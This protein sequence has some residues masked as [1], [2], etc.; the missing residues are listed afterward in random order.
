M[1]IKRITAVWDHSTSKGNARLLMLALADS[2]NDDGY[3]WPGYNHIQTKMN[4]GSRGTVSNTIEAQENA[5]ELIVDHRP[6]QGN[7][8][9]VIV[10]FSPEQV[11]HGLRTYFNMNESEVEDA[12]QKLKDRGSTPPKKGNK[13]KNRTNAISTETVLNK[14]KNRTGTSLKTVLDPL[15]PVIEPSNKDQTPQ[16]KTPLATKEQPTQS[17]Q[18]CDMPASADNRLPFFPDGTIS[19][20]EM[21]DHLDLTQADID[22]VKD[23]PETKFGY[24]IG[25][26]AWLVEDSDFHRFPT[27]HE[28]K[29]VRFT[30][31]MVEIE[32]DNGGEL[33]KA[34]RRPHTLSKTRP[35]LER[36]TT[37]IQDVIA[38]CLFGIA[39]DAPIG[40]RT[41]IDLNIYAGEITTPYPTITPE[42]VRAAFAWK[43]E[44]KPSKPSLLVKMLGDYRDYL[45]STQPS[46][47]ATAE[48]VTFIH[49]PA[50]PA[51]NYGMV[52]DGEGKSVQC[53]KCEALKEKGIV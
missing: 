26:T 16:E 43:G 47:G 1:S 28:V 2:A 53:A 42:Q 41:M 36:K 11:K 14:S 49:D 10:G 51:C 38:E 9:L 21:L 25:D 7:K 6:N 40:R 13:S 31:H 37:P 44:Y 12:Y 33:V 18:L 19:Y 8:Y 5:Q 23:E 3:C 34:L 24:T 45:V 20:D 22:A 27:I 4:C 15:V 30:K 17:E 39:H 50:C 32:Y 46:N 29:I 48:P 52:I 35:T